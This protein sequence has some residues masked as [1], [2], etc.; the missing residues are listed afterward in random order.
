M[1][2][3]IITL[4]FVL[5]FTGSFAQEYKEFKDFYYDVERNSRIFTQGSVNVDRIRGSMYLSRDFLQGSMLM[6]DSTLVGNVAFR[7]NI[8]TDQVEFFVIKESGLKDRIVDDDGNMFAARVEYIPKDTF[9][10]ALPFEVKEVV[11]GN[12]KMLYLLAIKGKGGKNYLT[13]GYFEVLT[14]GKCQLLLRR[15]VNIEVH[16][17]VPYYG[18]G[19]GD[20]SSYF[21]RYE[22][23]YY[24]MESGPATHLRKSR[25][26][27]LRIM[28]DKKA[29]M[30]EF[31]RREKINFG[32]YVDLVKVFDF[33][34]K[35][36][37]G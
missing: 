33:Y 32:S 26:N 18:G 17:F 8:F 36:S 14:D 16:S 37:N 12:R 27:L 2:R 10:I 15:E 19:G 20:G 24:R 22:K 30:S 35:I 9:T 31:I 3:K 34:N 23:L 5:V 13:S 7:Y 29:E 4:S 1:Y 11:M 21:A 6:K 25:R 28:G